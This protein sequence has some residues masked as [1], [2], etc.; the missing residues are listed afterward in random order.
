MSKRRRVDGSCYVDDFLFSVTAAEHSSCAGLAGR[1][2]DCLRAMPKAL[3]E[4]TFT[5][6]MLD[7]LHL[8]R[9]KKGTPGQQGGYTGVIIDTHLEKYQLTAKKEPK[10]LEAMAEAST[11]TLCSPRTMCKSHGKLVNFSVS[12]VPL[13]PAGDHGTIPAA[14]RN[15]KSQHFK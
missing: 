5:F 1:C 6:D 14:M 7:D 11:W 12:S 3:R 2:P 13:V 8:Q 15:S 10:L 4:Q 9:S